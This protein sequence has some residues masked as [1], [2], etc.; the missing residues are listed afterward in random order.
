MKK[1]VIVNINSG[2]FEQGFS[3]VNINIYWINENDEINS[4]KVY[5][6]FN[7]APELPANYDNWLKSYQELSNNYQELCKSYQRG[8]IK[9]DGKTKIP[10]QAEL[11]AKITKRI[12]TCNKA[13]EY[14]QESLNHWLSPVKEQL[15]QELDINA[16]EEI[17]VVIRTENISSQVTKEL[18]QKLPWHL[19]DFFSKENFTDVA[20]SFSDSEEVN[21]IYSEQMPLLSRPKR[22]K[23]LCILGANTLGDSK[24]EIDVEADRRFLRKIPGAYCVFLRQPK[25]SELIKFME[26]ERWDIFFFSGH[27]ET[28]QEDINTGYLYLKPEET[29][30]IREIK[31]KIQTA[32]QEYEGMK[33]A[34]FNSCNGLGL[35]RQLADLDIAQIIIWREPVPDKI[36]QEFLKS[37]LDSFCNTGLSLY[38]SVQKARLEVQEYIS[39]NDNLPRVSWLPVIHHNLAKESIA[40]EQLRGIPDIFIPQEETLRE[41]LLDKVKEFW[42]KGVLDK[43]LKKTP[44]ES[45]LD[46]V[47]EFW[48]RGILDKSLH[49]EE[50]IELGLSKDFDAVNNSSIQGENINHANRDL[51][52]G[53]RAIDV[54][55]ELKNKRTMLI[56]GEAG[57]GKTIALLEIARE[58]ISDAL[59]D[60]SLP[61]PVVLNLSSWAGE[62]QQKP[63]ADWLVQEL[64]RIYQFTEKQCK[65]WVK[66]QQLQLL[67]DGLDEVKQTKREREACIIAINQ[68]LREYERT[69]MVVCCRIE[70]YN[71]VSEKLQFQS[72]VF[73]KPLTE[74]QICRYFRDAKEELSVV[75]ELRK[76]EK[77]IRELL[78][79]PLILNIVTV[80]YKKKSKEEL[81]HKNSKEERRYHLYDTYIHRRF[82]EEQVSN[83]GSIALEPSELKYSKEQS[84]NWISWLAQKMN[85]K[86][87]EVLLIEQIQPDWLEAVTQKLTY[88]I[89]FRLILGI[90]VGIITVLHFGTQV[91]D[92][93]VDQLSLV[94][95]SVIAAL[96]SSLSS[97][98]L[99]SFMPRIIFRFIPRR[100]PT[101]ISKQISRFI[102][103]VISGFIYVIIAVALVYPLINE[104]IVTLLSPLMIDGAALSIILS[105]INQ[106]IG[107]IDILEGKRQKALRYLLFGLIGGSIY[108]LARWLLTDVYDT[109]SGLHGGLKVLHEFQY[110]PIIIELLIFTTL[111]GL[112]GYLDKGDNLEQT[113]IPNQGVWRSAKNAY[114]FFTIFF[115]VGIIFGIP[116]SENTYEAISIALAIGL[117]APLAGGK[118][119]VFAGFVLIQHFTL[120]MILWLQGFTPWNYAHFL[121]YATARIFLR[122]VGGG[123]IF[124]HRQLREHFAQISLER[125]SH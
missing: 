6:H 107:I 73:Y 58:S 54:F 114:I 48:I 16:E 84:L 90:I 37:F 69:E 2:S 101:H 97:L 79:S 67:L 38:R 31:E 81:S 64:N 11:I 44:R 110:A 68:F 55:G 113:V 23:I 77:A 59:Q 18:V 104:K 65:A 1:Q 8:S 4:H 14:L 28:P 27:S 111:P 99:F 92:N 29:I 20:L 45:L 56:L 123:Y 34:I 53:T 124:I 9:K 43:S 35:A 71:N 30:D 7:Q 63:L 75:D 26:Q 112:L 22:V 33:L 17:D 95:P 103:G 80:A 36:A 50:T 3:Q 87:Q 10:T 121:D 19:W 94:I 52:E 91:T 39:K 49:I 32:I 25:R 41:S 108:V 88:V 13:F 78:E 5:C 96:A 102:P 46:K 60:T 115:L 105:L 42:N 93:L 57:S 85:Q 100:I 62:K 89:S 117:L 120:R 74:D 51:P 116:Y 76:K 15:E 24:D 122:K 125:D 66:N 12:A 98:V 82:E 86:S 72:A 21:S 70:D 119:P 40:W 106:K 61:I 109:H 83:F 47:K 118:G